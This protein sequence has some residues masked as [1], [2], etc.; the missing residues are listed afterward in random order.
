[1]NVLM[2]DADKQNM[3]TLC[4]IFEAILEDS[5]VLKFTTPFAFVTGIYD[6]LK[7]NADIAFIHI[8]SN[9]DENI[10][11]ARDIQDY[12]PHIK[13]VFYSENVISAESIFYAV[14]SYYFSLPARER[15]VTS[16]FLRIREEIARD[17]D[18]SLHIISKG[19]LIKL[20]YNSIRYMESEGRKICIYSTAGNYETFSTMEE[21]MSRL[22]DNFYKCHRSYI[23][24]LKKII[25]LSQIG[26][27]IQGKITIPVSRNARQELTA[28]LKKQ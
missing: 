18:I 24:N 22:P 8:Q 13:V 12:F 26:V 2:L 4:S 14:P 7:G 20:K 6:E 19:Q 17:S 10:I 11:M 5:S 28:I 15:E 3:D 21:M 25:S 23:V 16:A 27:C 9:K 1:M